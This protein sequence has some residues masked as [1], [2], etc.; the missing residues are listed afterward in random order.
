M[1]R[2]KD[3]GSNMRALLMQ[4]SLL[5]ISCRGFALSELPRAV[6]IQNALFCFGCITQFRS[7]LVMPIYTTFSILTLCDVIVFVF[8]GAQKKLRS[9]QVM[10]EKQYNARPIAKRR[11]ENLYNL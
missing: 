10:M 3:L 11:E 1:G 5:K 7:I 9:I 8:I 2:E 4:K 6:C